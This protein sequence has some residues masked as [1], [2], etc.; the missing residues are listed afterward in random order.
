MIALL[1]SLAGATG[2]VARFC[3]DHAVRSRSKEQPRIPWTTIAIN[4]SGSFLL[5]V[6]AGWVMFRAGSTDVQAIVGSGFLGGYTTFS[7]ASVDTARLL[8]QGRRRDAA[9]NASVTVLASVLACSGGLAIA[10]VW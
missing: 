2:A 3:I 6:I 7:T 1:V 5:G 10:S 9:V 8:Q 4:I